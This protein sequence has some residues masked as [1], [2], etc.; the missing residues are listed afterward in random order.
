MSKFKQQI[1][2]LYVVQREKH[3]KLVTDPQYK[4]LFC[5]FDNSCDYINSA[6][7]LFIRG[8]MTNGSEFMYKI[9]PN[10]FNLE[11]TDEFIKTPYCNFIRLPLD[12]ESSPTISKIYQNYIITL[13]DVSLFMGYPLP[14]ACGGMYTL[15]NTLDETD[16]LLIFKK[17][18]THITAH[19]DKMMATNVD[20][21]NSNK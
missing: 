21:S 13:S 10:I 4:N 9:S 17:Y 8:Q 14:Y 16:E 3:R 15:D 5:T 2:E 20:I 18:L 1:D 6:D 12:P 19:F 11:V 7:V